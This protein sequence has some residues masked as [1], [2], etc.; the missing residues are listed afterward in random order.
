MTRTKFLSLS[1]PLLA[2]LGYSAPARGRVQE[3]S[4]GSGATEVDTLPMQKLVSAKSVLL[5]VAGR[6]TEGGASGL[7][8]TLLGMNSAAYEELADAV[9]KWKRF[10]IVT[11]AS[12]ADLVLLV[13]E[14]EDFH[15]WGNT[16]ACRDQL[17]VFEGG[18]LPTGKSQPLWRGDPEKWGKWGGCSGAGRTIIELRKEIEKA[19]KASRRASRIYSICAC[20]RGCRTL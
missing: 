14:W 6:P 8:G 20:S 2:L 18:V 12:K 19:E 9:R 5:L 11:D 10:D 7:F 3:V 16:V 1:L 15:R 13:V 17:F 4:S